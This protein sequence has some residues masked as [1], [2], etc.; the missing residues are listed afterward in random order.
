MNQN[1]LALYDDFKWKKNFDLQPLH[2]NI[3]QPY[4]GKELSLY[5]ART[6]LNDRCSLDFDQ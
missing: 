4:L 6:V 2:K 3:L 5:V 1:E